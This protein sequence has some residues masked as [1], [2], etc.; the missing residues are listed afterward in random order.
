MKKICYILL[1][2]MI[3]IHSTY[4]Q[5]TADELL[6]QGDSFYEQKKYKE[7]VDCYK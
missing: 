2:L 4:A 1:L 6:K 3:G 7:A 5:Q